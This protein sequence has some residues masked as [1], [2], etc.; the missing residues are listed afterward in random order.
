MQVH[1]SAQLHISALK[2]GVVIAI[3]CR[4]AVSDLPRQIPIFPAN[5]PSL[6][7]GPVDGL[8]ALGN[9]MYHLPRFDDNTRM[10]YGFYK[11]S[12]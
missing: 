1:T 2:V 5:P 3:R 10:N 7:L 4:L 11:V 6:S 9:C 8:R 12:V